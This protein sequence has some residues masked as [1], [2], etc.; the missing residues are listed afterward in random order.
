M[1]VLDE[2]I[3]EDQASRLRAW[4]I[5][6]EQ[7]GEGV[8]RVGMTDEDVIPLLHELRSVTFFSRD[9]DYYK[10]KLCHARYCLVY[11]DVH[12]K[13]TAETIRDL[14]RRPEFRTWAQRRGTVIRVTAEGMRVWR[15]GASKLEAIPWSS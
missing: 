9:V 5:H 1:H 10:R 4:R 8:G 7:V 6:Y 11:L 3:T 14:L 2:N 15:L 12:Q 13:R